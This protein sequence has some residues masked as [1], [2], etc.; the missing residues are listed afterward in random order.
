[1]DQSFYAVVDAREG[2]EFGQFRDVPSTT[3]PTL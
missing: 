3:S 2:A 1:M